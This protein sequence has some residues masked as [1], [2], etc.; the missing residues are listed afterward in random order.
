MKYN[1]S[2]TIVTLFALIILLMSCAT[3]QTAVEKAKKARLIDEQIENLDFKFIANYAYPQG[4]Q[5]I[6]RA[7]CRERV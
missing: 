7:S 6:G 4:Y 3:S 2:Y 1:K 5:Q